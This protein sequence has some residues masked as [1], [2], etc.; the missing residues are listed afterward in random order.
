[1]SSRSHDILYKF[2]I[3]WF[4]QLHYSREIRSQKSRN[5]ERK[6]DQCFFDS[7][8][9]WVIASHEHVNAFR[10]FSFLFVSCAVIINQLNFECIADES[11]C[12]WW[13]FFW[14]NKWLVLRRWNNGIQSVIIISKE[15]EKKFPVHVQWL[16]VAWFKNQ[17]ARSEKKRGLS[18]KSAFYTRIL[19]PRL[20]VSLKKPFNGQALYSADGKTIIFYQILKID[21]LKKSLQFST[22][23][24]GVFWFYWLQKWRLKKGPQLRILTSEN[25]LNLPSGTVYGVR[26]CFIIALIG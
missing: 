8:T 21:D 14:G 3:T 5:G 17:T 11:C 1:M 12:F 24:E 15:E 6:I 7:V 20:F 22:N 16:S 2:M 9:V 4:K 26:I 25:R 18:S 10:S 23:C 19:Q 13:C